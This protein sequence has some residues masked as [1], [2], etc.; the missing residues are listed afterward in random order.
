MKSA[1]RIRPYHDTPQ[2]IPV[3]VR[4][5]HRER[6]GSYLIRVATANHCPPWSFLRLIGNL[7]GQQTE[8][9]T[10]QACVTMNHPALLRLAIYLGRPL[11]E[12]TVSLPWIA[13]DDGQGEPTIR[14]RRLGRTF[15]RS[16]PRCE[17]RAGT[18]MM[19]GL[20]PLELACRQHNQG[21][22]TDEHISLDQAHDTAS[23][24]KRLGRLRRRYGD[25]LIHPLYQ[26]IHSY[27][28]DDWRGLDW[29]RT[30]V[31]RWIERQQREYPAAHPNDEFVRS[32]TQHWS[33]L[34]ETL[35]L[36]GALAGRPEL[37]TADD[38]NRALGLDRYWSVDRPRFPTAPDAIAPLSMPL[39]GDQRVARAHALNSIRLI[40]WR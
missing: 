21:R 39:T 32:R 13:A 23:A 9:L 1:L 36:I 18:P 15:L 16:C 14:I 19:P 38:I 22:V 25:D 24:I 8:H 35:N 11:D 4:P 29:H 31:R 17:H 40:A 37:F 26:R 12:L 2:P 33:M 5:H 28:T 7:G 3:S 34:P 10:P 27:M 20:N 6:T 30:L